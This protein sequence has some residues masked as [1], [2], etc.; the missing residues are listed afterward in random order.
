M[1][2]LLKVTR[3]AKGQQ[4]PSNVVGYLEFTVSPETAPY[5]VTSSKGLVWVS[6]PSSE[7]LVRAALREGCAPVVF[8]RE[9]VLS[10]KEAGVHYDWGNVLPLTLEGVQKAITHLES[11]DQGEIEILVPKSSEDLH[12]MCSGFDRAVRP[13]SWLPEN[14]AVVVPKDRQFVGGVWRVNKNAISGL[15]HNAARGMVILV[16]LSETED[17]PNG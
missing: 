5:L 16:D 7:G 17:D 10:V 14:M 12:R 1:S 4:V 8:F 13:S 3:L 15:V 6:H 9:V 11:Y 2:D